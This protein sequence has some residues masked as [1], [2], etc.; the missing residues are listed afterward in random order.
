MLEDERGS[1]EGGGKTHWCRT[2]R[3]ARDQ[4]LI[5]IDADVIERLRGDVGDAAASPTTQSNEIY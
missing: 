3:A 4:F 2:F 5:V 1:A